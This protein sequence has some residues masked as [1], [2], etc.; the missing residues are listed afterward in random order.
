MRSNSFD[1]PVLFIVFNKPESTEKV[2]N[3][4]RSIKPKKFYIAGDG[5]R[6][7]ID[8]EKDSCEKVKDIVSKVDWECDCKTLFQAENLGC[9]LGVSSAIDW[10]FQNEEEGIIIE[11]D[12]FP[13][14]SFFYYCREL[15]TKYKD[16]Q[17]IMG[18]GGTNFFKSEEINQEYS[19][20]F[21][22]ES[23]IWG[24]ATW[25][26]AW[27]Y[28]DLHAENYKQLI[29]SKY[30]KYNFSNYY[31]YV[32]KKYVFELN[33]ENMSA[34]S[35]QWHLARLSQSGLFIAP[36]TNMIIN[37]GIG[38]ENATNTKKHS[39]IAHRLESKLKLNSID[40]PL[41][42]PTNVMWDRE[43]DSK[44]FIENFTTKSTRVKKQI[45]RLIPKSI[46]NFLLYPVYK[47][48]K[49]N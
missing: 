31:E 49:N 10:L 18:I 4:I 6:G 7:H 26:R 20:Y 3:Q 36:N 37:L 47:L 28:F 34:W 27:K 35:Y 25:R 1:T 32:Y 16:D 39:K 41:K 30:F 19:Y 29:Q 9:A 44:F 45:R 14:L 22:N 21:S 38:D 46:F 11:D 8:G 43:L 48:I 33:F 12:V 5:P 13:D 40:L 17:R 24:W 42:H 15:L 23:H 2:F